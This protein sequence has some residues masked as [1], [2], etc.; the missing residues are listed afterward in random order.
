MDSLQGQLLIA[1][2]ELVD[3][4]FRRTVVLLVQHGDE[5]A[6]GLVLNRPTKI[7]IQEAWQQISETSCTINERL[8]LGGPCEGPLMVL[9][10]HEPCGDIEVVPGLHFT[11]NSDQIEQL[12][13]EGTGPVRFFAGYAGWGAT[14][15][16][17]ELNEGSWF[18]AP[19]T[20]ADALESDDGLWDL[21]M[22]RV[23]DAQLV[24]ALHIK[25]IP[26]DLRMN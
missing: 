7:P 22:K 3:P 11:S 6:L 21:A 13:A 9:H 24:S 25:H 5:G 2:R 1:S 18:V 10:A 14:Q 12:V 16:E 19:A 8:R 23:G 17:H 15:L 26:P 20:L 4:N